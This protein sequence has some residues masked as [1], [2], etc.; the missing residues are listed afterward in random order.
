MFRASSWIYISLLCFIRSDAAKILGV[1]WYPAASHQAIY[2]PI[3][4]E[5][6]LRGHEVTAITVTPLRD[7][8]L[9]NLTEIDIGSIFK[10]TQRSDVTKVFSKENSFWYTLYS[11]KHLVGEFLEEMFSNVGVRELINSKQ[12]FDVVIV[13]PL[14]EVVFAFGERFKAPV[15]GECVFFLVLARFNTGS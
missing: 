13:E 9:K 1:A 2:Q 4:R 5:L 11:G 12:T 15:I 8:N 6:S 14:S 7:P 10:I 3:W